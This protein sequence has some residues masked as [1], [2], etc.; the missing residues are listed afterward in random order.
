MVLGCEYVFVRAY[1]HQ[2]LN[3]NEDLFVFIERFLLQCPVVRVCLTS[4]KG[5]RNSSYEKHFGNKIW[6]I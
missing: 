6:T 3:S 5:V 1:S 4:R 2:K